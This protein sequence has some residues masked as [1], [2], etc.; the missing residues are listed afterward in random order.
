MRISFLV[1]ELL[2]PFDMDL[3]EELTWYGGA[4]AEW[5]LTAAGDAV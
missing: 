3:G 1:V 4:P 2:F 5:R